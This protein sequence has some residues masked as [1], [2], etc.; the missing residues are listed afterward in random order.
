MLKLANLAEEL[1]LQKSMLGHDNVLD[2][3]IYNNT[4]NTLNKI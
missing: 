3:K 2:L 4:K 1:L